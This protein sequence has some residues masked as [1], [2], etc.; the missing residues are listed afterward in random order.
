MDDGA[1]LLKLGSARLID[2]DNV[3]LVNDENEEFKVN[4]TVFMIWDM[5]NNIRFIDL[6]SSLEFGANN[7]NDLRSTLERLLLELRDNKL[8]KIRYYQ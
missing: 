4:K 2:R 5:C 3:I 1:I 7:L 6:L 8:L